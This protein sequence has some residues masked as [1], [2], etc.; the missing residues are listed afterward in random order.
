MDAHG[1]GPQGP[2]QPPSRG[3][4]VVAIDGTED[5]ERALRY[6]APLAVRTGRALAILH[7]IHEPPA[8]AP[9][10]PLFAAEVLTSIGEG[11][12]TEAARLA[13]ALAG[14]DAE[15]TQHLADGPRAAT[16][17]AYAGA[18]PVVVA[19][20]AAAFQRL[21]TGATTVAVAARARGPV[22]CV[23]RSW[24][25]VPPG[26]APYG[27]V[28]VGVDGGPTSD[29]VLGH[30]F[31]AAAERGAR[32]IVLH[33]WRPSGIYDAAV[34]SSGLAET[35]ERQTE[36]VVWQRLAGHRGAFP[37]VEV[38]VLLRFTRPEVA[39][40]DEAR[41]ADLVVLGRRTE[42]G[43]VALGTRTRALLHAG[44]CPVAVAPVPAVASRMPA[45]RRGDREAPSSLA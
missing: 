14:E 37:H 18:D 1:E 39:L 8:T 24:R 35:W 31:A 17:V 16:I 9:M 11:V 26:G 7:V 32:L 44:L 33:A 22:L 25:P 30:A 12:L 15:I 28:V 36:P 13:R 40:A 38:E 23:P 43:A 34:S 2:P 41:H 4:L 27:R 20:R 10:L 19:T 29:Q 21:L 6:A 42:H 3:R 45:Q 5:G